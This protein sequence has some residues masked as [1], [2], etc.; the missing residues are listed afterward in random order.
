MLRNA[1]SPDE[2]LI[3]ESG[4]HL[5]R[6]NYYETIF[7][8]GNGRTGTRG[9]LEEGHLGELA[10]SFL[11]GV[12]DSTDS[13][14]TNLVNAPDW[15]SL[16]VSVDG[17]RLDVQSST[18]IEHERALDLRQGILWRATVFQDGSG[19]Q[20]RVETIRMAS[21][22]HR[23]LCA[24][25]AEI[26]PLNHRSLITVESALDGR[27]RNLERLPAYP[28]DTEFSPWAK[29]EK[30]ARSKHLTE[31]A[32]VSLEEGI[33]LEMQTI[34]SGVSLGYAAAL[35]SSHLPVERRV[36][37]RHELI[38]EHVSFEISAGE[39]LHVDKLVAIS[40]SRD[41]LEGMT[42]R[43][44]TSQALAAH[45]AAGFDRRLAE[46]VE[47][48]ERL[49]S[50]SDCEIVGDPDAAKAVRF[51]I[52]HLLIA[53]NPDDP[54]T[55]IGAKSLSGEG[56]RGHVFWD[57][58]IMMLPFFT[59]TQPQAA[60]ALLTYRHHTLPGA[61][62]VSGEN[63]TKGARYP[64]ESADTGRE[65]CPQWTPDGLNRFWT[66]DEEVHVS[67]DVAYG[68]LSYVAATGDRDFLLDYGAE[69]L[70]ETS[71]FWSDRV[72]HDAATDSYSI[73]QVMGPDEFHSHVNDNAFTNRMVRWH[74]SQ[75]AN[76]HQQLACSH[77]ER[78]QELSIS[79]G[80]STEEV[81][82]W[83][84]V[85]SKIV[86]ASDAEAS[87]IEQFDGYFSLEDVPITR[88][89]DNDMPQYPQGYHHFNCEDTM[90]LKQ[91]DVLMLM[92]LLPD[93]FNHETKKSNYDFYEKRTLHKSSL[94]PAIHAILGLEVGDSTRALQYFNRSAFV[95]LQ[96]NQGNTDEGIHIAS[97]GGTWQTVV[98]GFAGF[99][100]LEGQMSFSPWLPE[101]WSR[102]NFSIQWHGSTV[103]VSLEHD[104]AT[105]VLEGG[106]SGGEL[107]L[108][109]GRSVGL[110]T[111]QATTV[112]IGLTA[113][114]VPA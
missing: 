8:V 11:G 10:G 25:R 62:H 21:M 43:G 38:A 15:L 92:Y 41:N 102:V 95:D 20:T 7:T 85:A 100:V 39:T 2:W 104:Q 28:E 37:Q 35:E 49:W 77:P 94:S 55:S 3:K 97:A 112:V 98:N 110:Q 69:I 36:T 68:V 32:R 93:D 108:V 57:T 86:D 70:F 51:N 63:G 47:A 80:L 72:Q 74:L 106:H 107:I 59:Y 54:E 88:W 30:W 109:S 56:Y 5:A 103:R 50:A 73:N 18:V 40:T 60:R 96:D 91:A 76:L 6:S 101:H 9:S 58:E 78:L 53:A 13:P 17:E 89:D 27:R 84:D 87:V 1:L 65:E 23:E 81:L 64:W 83:Q 42:I 61:R 16:S 48:W 71:R 19:R 82:L 90:L 26:T 12:Y 34:Q 105:F 114:A 75:S 79:L 46:S 22:A 29:W 4:L 111:G 24:I 52:Y 14:V 31:R 66:R 45:R 113:D 99:R 33:Y 44:R 67:A